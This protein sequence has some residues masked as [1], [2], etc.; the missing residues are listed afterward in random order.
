MKASSGADASRRA[1]DGSPGRSRIAGS[2]RGGPAPRR[3]RARHDG[4]RQ[5]PCE[6]ATTRSLSAGAPAAWPWVRDSGR[7]RL[8]SMRAG[9][10]RRCPTTP[11]ALRDEGQRDS[12]M[13]AERVHEVR[14]GRPAERLLVDAPDRGDVARPRGPDGREL[15]T[16]RRH[17]ASGARGSGSAEAGLRRRARPSPPTRPAPRRTRSRDWGWPPGRRSPGWRRAG[18]RCARSR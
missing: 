2:T 18:S 8:E 4:T 7:A 12:A 10:K 17:G 15:S 13:R 5:V 6:C 3:I 9:L 11:A 1:H 14:L 16:R